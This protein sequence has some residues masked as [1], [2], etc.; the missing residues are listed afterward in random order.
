MGF[1]FGFIVAALVLTVLFTNV[2]DGLFSAG[3]RKRQ[4]MAEEAGKLQKEVTDKF[5]TIM[6]TGVETV[7]VV[8][9]IEGV[10]ENKTEADQKPT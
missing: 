8:K 2:M 3:E 5:N 4:E 6:E 1:L 9:D 7:K 10:Q